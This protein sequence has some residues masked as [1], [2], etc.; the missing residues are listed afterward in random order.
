MK[1]EQNCSLPA[2]SRS[3]L[4]QSSG[5]CAKVESRQALGAHGLCFLPCPRNLGYT[6]Q[7]DPPLQTPAHAS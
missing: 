1:M 4:G 2:D 5:I 7:K 6:H 3:H